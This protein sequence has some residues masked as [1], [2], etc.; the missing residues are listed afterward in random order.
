MIKQLFIDPA[1]NSTG[2]ALFI[3]GVCTDSGTI[4]ASKGPVFKRLIDIHAQYKEL[5]SRIKPDEVRF[6]RMN[7]VVNVA[8]IWSVGAIGVALKLGHWPANIKSEYSEQISPSTWKKY[9]KENEVF[10]NIRANTSS[11]D[12]AVAVLLGLAYTESNRGIKHE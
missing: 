3:D 7:R 11:N 8:V 2:W 12:E 4:E 5:G 1:S 6:E 10:N 9:E